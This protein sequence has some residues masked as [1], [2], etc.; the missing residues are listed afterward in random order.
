M[1]FDSGV[2]VGVVVNTQQYQKM[3]RFIFNLVPSVADVSSDGS[4]RTQNGL[5]LL[6]DRPCLGSLSAL[7]RF[8]SAQEA[9]HVQEY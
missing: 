2:V 3:A 4:C 6:L 8:I 7:A 5:P 9:K 1:S